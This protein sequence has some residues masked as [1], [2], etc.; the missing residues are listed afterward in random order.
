MGEIEQ[1]LH[2]ISASS[3]MVIICLSQQKLLHQSINRVQNLTE[4]GTYYVLDD[5]ASTL[6]DQRN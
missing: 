2:L 1:V 4:L 5:V 6:T 3:I